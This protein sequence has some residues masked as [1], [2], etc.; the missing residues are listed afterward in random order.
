VSDAG[1]PIDCGK[2]Q[3]DAEL[4]AY[5]AEMLE[6]VA[7]NASIAVQFLEMGDDIG[8]EYA[9]RRGA[10]YFRAAVGTLALLKSSKRKEVANAA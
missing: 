7:R 5:A 4:R 1:P 6:G 10:A 2:A 8:A 3:R 9:T